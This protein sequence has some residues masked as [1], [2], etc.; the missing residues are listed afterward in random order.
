M[1]ISCPLNTVKRKRER[2][3]WKQIAYQT[4]IQTYRLTENEKEREC[5]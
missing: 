3:S 2:K 4:D 5:V 1:I